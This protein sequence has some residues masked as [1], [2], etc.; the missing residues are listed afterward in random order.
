MISLE[1][2]RI[3]LVVGGIPGFLSFQKQKGLCAYIQSQ[4]QR[5]V[6]M[7]VD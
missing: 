7:V 3:L 2:K 5:A 1:M 4:C 6:L